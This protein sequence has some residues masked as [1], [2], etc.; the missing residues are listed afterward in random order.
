M[1]PANHLAYTDI[2]LRAARDCRHKRVR[3]RLRAAMN[4]V[5][6]H[7]PK[8]DEETLLMGALAGVMRVSPDA[9]SQALQQELYALGQISNK[10]N[11]ADIK[12]EY[13]VM[14]EEPIGLLNL[15][16]SC[17]IAHGLFRPEQPETPQDG[18]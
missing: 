8:G 4:A 9:I 3:P 18:G 5:L 11:G 16:E 7:D 10:M 15:W 14:P 13:I 17:R 12:D 2:A 1:D 6:D